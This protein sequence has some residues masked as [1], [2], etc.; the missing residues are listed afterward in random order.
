MIHCNFRLL[1]FSVSLSIL[2]GCA[3][4]PP[5]PQWQLRA[6]N[7]LDQFTQRSLVGDLRSAESEFNRA[8][9]ALSRTGNPGRV[10]QAELI[11][12]AV[13][14]AGLDIDDCPKFGELQAHADRADQAYFAYLTLYSPARLSAAP[15]QP[16]NRS[17]KR[18]GCAVADRPRTQFIT[19]TSSAGCAFFSADQRCGCGG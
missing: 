8:A 16:P 18:F 4:S 17:D 10:A 5:P 12:C 7:A 2:A 19:R 1:V 14:L 3:S 13:R 15:L 9:D 6:S 11:R